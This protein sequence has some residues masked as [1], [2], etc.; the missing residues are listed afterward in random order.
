MAI[1]KIPA[2]AK[3]IL[4]DYSTNLSAFQ[5]NARLFLAN[6]IIIGAAF[7]VFRLLF[8]FYVLSLGFDE[9]LL[10][11]LITASS[12][13]ALL[14]A[15]PMG[16][17]I[18]RIGQKRAL[19][20]GSLVEGL[21]VAGMI[22]LPSAPML[23]AMNVVVGLGQSLTGVAM[24]PFLMEN[25]SEKER[26]YLFSLTSGLQMT[27]AFVGNWI[28]GYLPTWIAGWQSSDPT[29]SSAYSASLAAI[30]IIAATSALPL[31]FLRI[32]RK[33]SSQGSSFAPFSYFAKNSKLLSR[34]ILPMLTTSLG[35]GLIMPFM[36]VFFRNVHNQPDPVIGSLFAW[37]SL[38]M[39]VGL[40]I[41]PPLA[42]RYGKIQVVVISQ[43][44]SIPF[45]F[46]LGF[47]PWYALSAFSYYIRAG[48]MNMSLP[49]YQTFV[50]ERVGPSE[51]ATVASLV[52][53]ATNLG[54]AFS[55]TVS[56]WIQVNYG[57]SPAFIA[58]IVLYIVSIYLYW[59]YFWK[60]T[61]R[62]SPAQESALV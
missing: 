33:Q 4:A 18:G 42:D 37:C 20:F 30:S 58:T 38:A 12:L 36:N 59:R 24:G 14:A 46:A 62:T 21:A 55:P 41:A 25:S 28:G 47:S 32:N 15:L 43:A 49:V 5:P 45:L 53:M 9:T 60:R 51:R 13:T 31:L 52:S 40:L 7:G 11:T 6:V 10:G 29:S 22:A 3:K 35:A 48:L 8:N 1:F 19:I 44:L 34:L 50:M 16:Y 57:F 26:T 23:I 61:P 39:G 56:G 17:L 54:W 2:S 27:S